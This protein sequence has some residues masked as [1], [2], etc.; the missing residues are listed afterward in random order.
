MHMRFFVV[1]AIVA[2][3]A[4]G[5]NNR[6]WAEAR[7]EVGGS[8]G[9]ASGNVDTD[10]ESLFATSAVSDDGGWSG[11]AYYSGN[12]TADG[13]TI[14][15][16]HGTGPI[17]YAYIQRGNGPLS[18]A[19]AG[20]QATWGDFVR[21]DDGGDPTTL[22]LLPAGYLAN[23]YLGLHVVVDAKVPTDG[24]ADI[25]IGFNG[26]T[27]RMSF[28]GNSHWLGTNFLEP[29]AAQQQTLAQGTDLFIDASVGINY[30]PSNA[31]AEG[32]IN[33]DYHQFYFTLND[34]AG[35]ILSENPYNLR[36][37]SN[38]LPGLVYPM[39]PGLVPLKGDYN[40]DHKVDA[41][42]YVAWR[43]ANGTSSIPNEG[44]DGDGDGLV[45]MADFG[46]WRD[47][48]GSTPSISSSIG[49]SVSVPEPGSL[50]LLCV[51][52]LTIALPI[53]QSRSIPS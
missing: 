1:S 34:A 44:A 20:S 31:F 28:P 5:S 11:S 35:H 52:W 26:L 27:Q 15:Y 13:S 16:A 50:L 36:I 40:R 8:F 29:V 3:I 32:W 6:A 7:T 17:L 30:G 14:S 46:V 42:D 4:F 43:R 37:V 38:E 19:S 39:R 41:A 21:L 24:G 9:E 48:F 2:V 23:L 51:G 18:W 53:R 33:F 22:D 47:N 45:T 25:Q 12:D 49:T 10:Q